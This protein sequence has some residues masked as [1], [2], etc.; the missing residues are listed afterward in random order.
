MVSQLLFYN[1]A[2][3]AS[4]WSCIGS[5]NLQP[6]ANLNLFRTFIFLSFLNVFFP[7]VDMKQS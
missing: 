1:K 7:T 5:S 4:V 3:A 2:L 6:P